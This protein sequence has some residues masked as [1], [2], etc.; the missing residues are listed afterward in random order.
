MGF[1][2]RHGK[3]SQ[4]CR[5]CAFWHPPQFLIA[6]RNGSI[7]SF[8]GCLPTKYLNISSFGSLTEVRVVISDWKNE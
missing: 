7:E 2:A 1:A 8:N 3:A 5:A 6:W 4:I